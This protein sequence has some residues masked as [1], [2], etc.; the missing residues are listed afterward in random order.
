MPRENACH[1]SILLRNSVVVVN[2]HC[3]AILPDGTGFGGNDQVA[4]SVNEGLSCLSTLLNSLDYAAGYPPPPLAG[5]L[6]YSNY[7]RTL[8]TKSVERLGQLNRLKILAIAWWKTGKMSP[9]LVCEL[10]LGTAR[11]LRCPRRFC[12]PG[13]R[14]VSRRCRG[15]GRLTSAGRGRRGV[16][17]WRGN[18]SG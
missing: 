16:V 18:R 12:R 17:A 7:Q 4:R 5:P 8:R 3:A 2:R 6:F 11:A 9:Y 14:A 15:V 13:R 1:K 10:R